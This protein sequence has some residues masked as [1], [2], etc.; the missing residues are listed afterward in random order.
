MK[1]SVWLVCPVVHGYSSADEV[2]SDLKELYA[3]VRHGRLTMNLGQRL[4]GD[5]VLPDTGHGLS[6]AKWTMRRVSQDRDMRPLD[7]TVACFGDA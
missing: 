6:T 4:N 7:A 3:Q 1:D 5:R 2:V